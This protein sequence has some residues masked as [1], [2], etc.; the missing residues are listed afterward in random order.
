MRPKP[1]GR[2]E[3]ILTVV[4]VALVAV[5]TVSALAFGDLMR[6]PIAA[7]KPGMAAPVQIPGPSPTP[8][9]VEEPVTTTDV[10]EHCVFMPDDYREFHDICELFQY[11][12]GQLQLSDVC[13]GPDYMFVGKFTDSHWETFVWYQGDFAKAL[14]SNL[15]LDLTPVCKAQVV[16]PGMCPGDFGRSCSRIDPN[17]DFQ[18][19]ESRELKLLQRAADDK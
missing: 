7:Q 11:G 3:L 6:Q 5:V 2:N 14:R 15:K 1:T 12:C 13:P 10:P 9:P 8:A 4:S 19:F 18:A 16:D 17:L